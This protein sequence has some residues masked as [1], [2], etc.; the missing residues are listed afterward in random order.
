MPVILMIVLV[1]VSTQQPGA[2]EGIQFYIG[3]FDWSELGYARVWA[4]ALSQILFSLSPGFGTA[5]TY[6]SFVGHKEDVYRTGLIVAFCNSA[7][8]VLS[9]FAIFSIVGYM[10]Y[11]EG[12]PVEEGEMITTIDCR[13]DMPKLR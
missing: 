12:V 11:E 5:I 4:T 6:S 13:D 2:L 10:A 7:F 8:S 9:G 1:I 3:K